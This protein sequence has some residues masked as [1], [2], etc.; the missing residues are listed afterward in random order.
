VLEDTRA[1]DTR[2]LGCLWEYSL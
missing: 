1:L 2:A